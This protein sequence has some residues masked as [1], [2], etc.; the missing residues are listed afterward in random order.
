MRPTYSSP[1]QKKLLMLKSPAMRKVEDEIT[2]EEQEQNKMIEIFDS[3]DL[4]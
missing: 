1:Q 4:S 3:D 2:R